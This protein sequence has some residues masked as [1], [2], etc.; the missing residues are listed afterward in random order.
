MSYTHPARQRFLAVLRRRT[1][2]LNL[3]EAALCI[4]WEDRGSGDPDA[5]LREIDLI[6]AS[7]QV[8]LAGE[9][10]T[11]TIIS[12]LNSYLFED[13][14]FRG[15]TWH[16]NDPANSYIDHVLQTRAGLPITLAVVYLEVGWRIG[17]PVQG[18]ALPGHFIVHYAAPEQSFFIDPFNRGR[19]WSYDE[20]E[21]QVRSFY[22]NAAPEIMRQLL[23]APSRQAILARMLRNLKN[24][25]LERDDFRRSLAAVD[26]IMLVIGE[27]AQE[28]RDRGLLRARLNQWGAALSDLERYTR[29]APSASDLD[30]VRQQA[31]I[32]AEYI[33]RNN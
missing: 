17:L 19:L 22:G 4:A 18:L 3:A 2:E 9:A 26:R 5:S 14:G 13:L 12:L 11:P 32:L 29:L 25:Y 7:A 30:L 6:A 15:N 21:S 31:R 16:Q 1:P 23:A 20:C 8:R 10:H 24:A 33:G 28:L 27:D